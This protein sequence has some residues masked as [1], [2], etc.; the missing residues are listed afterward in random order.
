MSS[1]GRE[2]NPS[3]WLQFQGCTWLH[4]FCCHVALHGT[5]YNLSLWTLNCSCLFHSFKQTCLLKAE[6]DREQTEVFVELIE[7]LRSLRYF[8]QAVSFNV[9]KPSFAKRDVWMCKPC[10]SLWLISWAFSALWP[11]S[12]SGSSVMAMS[13]SCCL[14]WDFIIGNKVASTA[15]K[16]LS[17]GSVILLLY[18]CFT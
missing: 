15:I 14:K 13:F 9:P 11:D 16:W 1:T 3:W 7:I 8:F 6:S 12:S 2:N 17:E 4:I 18:F 5:Q 10:N